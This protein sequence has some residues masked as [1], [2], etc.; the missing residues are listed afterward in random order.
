MTSENHAERA[1]S[2]FSASGSERWLKCAASVELE[3]KSPPS[4]DNVWSLEGTKAHEVLE[5]F[6]LS[7]NWANL[8]VEFKKDFSVDAAMIEHC[9]TTAVKVLKLAK[10]WQ[11]PLLVEKRIYNSFIHDE[12]FGT[13][14]V[15]IPVHSDVLHIMDFKYGQGHIVNPIENTQL[16][17]YA[18]GAAESYDW[19]FET[20]SMHILQPRAGTTWHKTW[21]ITMKELRTKWLPLWH[22]GVA[23]IE[24][25][26]NKPFAG[27]WCHW[28]R[29]KFT[30]PAKT[31]RRMTEITNM[32]L[33]EPITKGGLNG[34]EEKSKKE[35]SQKKYKENPF[36]KKESEDFY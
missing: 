36:L 9:K 25:G 22:R 32:F 14:D 5:K 1:H 13:C 18:L 31:E 19:D 17:Q 27:S 24:K 10:L 12:M 2:K 33:D 15:V 34:A 23:R 28:C 7:N 8:I 4:K 21:T 16:I 3:E 20:V 30:C 11:A 29:A 35:S 6:L 26:G